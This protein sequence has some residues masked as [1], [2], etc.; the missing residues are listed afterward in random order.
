M[1]LDEL[2]LVV[3]L[4]E[5]TRWLYSEDHHLSWLGVLKVFL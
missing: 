3:C 1:H 5:P 2:V 4:E